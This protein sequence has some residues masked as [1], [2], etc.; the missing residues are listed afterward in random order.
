MKVAFFGNLESN[1]SFLLQRHGVI[2]SVCLSKGIDIIFHNIYDLARYSFSNDLLGFESFFS[3]YIGDRS[4]VIVHKEVLQFIPHTYLENLRKRKIPIIG[5]IGDEEIDKYGAIECAVNFDLSVVYVKSIIEE[6]NK[7]KLPYYFMPEGADFN[8]NRTNSQLL[9]SPRFEVLFIGKPYYPRPRIINSLIS[10]GVNIGVFGSE[11]WGKHIPEDNYFGFVSN[12]DYN[13]VISEA[14][15]LLA[16]MEFG[17][18]EE[19]HMNAKHFD[20]AV[21]GVMSIG[22]YYSPFVSEFGLIEGFNYSSYRTE[23]DLLDK[24]IH[25]LDND[26][27]RKDMA[28]EQTIAFRERFDYNVLYEGFFDYLLRKKGDLLDTCKDDIRGLEVYWE[29]KKS[30]NVLMSNAFR[31]LQYYDYNN[32]FDYLVCHTVYQNKLVFK[33]LNLFDQDSVCVKSNAIL[34]N[35]KFGLMSLKSARYRRT[36][37]LTLNEQNNPKI[38]VLALFKIYIIIERIKAA[39]WKSY[40]A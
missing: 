10:A 16:L 37:L 8:I 11:E 29:R 13:K 5:F 6:L 9:K 26:A 20:A 12:D 14:K 4:L 38:L 1:S 34:E 21:N 19:P 27:V 28:S 35:K 17:E 23:K 33:R 3:K 30:G 32:E 40:R 22:T 36:N 24:I 15:I 2:E 31:K 7:L 39:Y 18:S 25:Y